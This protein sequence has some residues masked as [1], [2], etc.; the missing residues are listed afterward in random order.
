MIKSE[1]FIPIILNGL[2]NFEK[3]KTIDIQGNII[4]NESAKALCHI[5]EQTMTL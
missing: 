1:P 5:I 2:K 3:L 4:N